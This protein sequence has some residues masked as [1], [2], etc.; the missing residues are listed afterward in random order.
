[1]NKAGLSQAPSYGRNGDSHRDQF[2]PPAANYI[3]SGSRGGFQQPGPPMN[4]REG[5]PPPPGAVSGSLAPG[6]DEHIQMLPPPLRDEVMVSNCQ[7]A[8]TSAL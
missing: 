6:S 8:C 2:A 7:V 4:Q 3:Q 5:R 1:M